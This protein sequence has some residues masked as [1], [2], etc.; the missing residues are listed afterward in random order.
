MPKKRATTSRKKPTKP[1]PPCRPSTPYDAIA[2]QLLSC[3]PILAFVLKNTV[4]EL[5]DCSIETIADELIEERVMPSSVP[6]DPWTV[7][8]PLSFALPTEDASIDEG[9]VY[10]DVLLRVR[11]PHSDGS[12]G[13][14]V[15]IEPQSYETDYPVLK[16][17]A[18]YC[19]RLL[20][21]QRGQGLAGSDYERLEKVY[22]IWIFSGPAAHPEGSITS[23][24][25]QE[26][27]VEGADSHALNEY[28]LL[29]ILLVRPPQQP[30]YNGFLEK[31]ATLFSLETGKAEK[32]KALE[33][34][35]AWGI[36]PE[37]EETMGRLVSMGEYAIEYGEARGLD[38]GRKESQLAAV[39]AI[40]KTQ[41]FTPKQALDALEITNEDDRSYYLEQI[42]QS[43]DNTPPQPQ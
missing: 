9:S 19:A 27:L 15:N 3:L 5:R 36:T 43:A 16:R 11:L 40:M 26:Q 14:V 1:K 35:F 28:D 10:Y 34:D 33:N 4:T 8:S 13:I 12:V 17:A 32:I 29:S 21:A 31:L 2:K 6:V 39:R 7:R 24:T 38:K 23:Y 20:S 30:G 41:G 25:L 22:S 42:E 18:Y 37:V